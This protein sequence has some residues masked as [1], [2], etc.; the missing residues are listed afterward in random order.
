MSANYRTPR[1]TRQGALPAGLPGARCGSA[2]KQPV[3]LGHLITVEE[4]KVHCAAVFLHL[5]DRAKAWDGDGLGAGQD[6]ADGVAACHRP[7]PS[8]GACRRSGWPANRPAAHPERADLD[9]GAP[10]GACQSP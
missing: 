1:S 10:K 2:L 3:D 4:A 6:L 9:P 7:R 5:L 8:R